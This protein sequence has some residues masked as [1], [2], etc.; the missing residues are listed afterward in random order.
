M[1]DSLTLL[2]GRSQL[3]TDEVTSIEWVWFTV[4]TVA[5]QVGV[6]GEISAQWRCVTLFELPTC[7]ARWSRRLKGIAMVKCQLQTANSGEPL[8]TPGII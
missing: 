3:A 2:R 5:S 1:D 6:R 8:V 7:S 4:G